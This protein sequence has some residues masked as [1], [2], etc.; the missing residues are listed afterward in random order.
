MSKQNFQVNDIRPQKIMA[1]YKKILLQDI[2]YLIKQKKDFIKINCP[3]C[4]G[5]RSTLKF[6]KYSLTYFE[7]K[8]CNTVYVNPRPTEMILNDFFKQS[9]GYKYWNDY[10]FPASEKVRR[11]KIFKPRV[12]KILRICKQ[13]SIPSET[14]VEV[15]AG[16]GTFL[17]E[18]S[19][20]K[21]FNSLIGIEPTPNL[22][23][24]CRD[25]NLNIIEK[26]IEEISPKTLKADVVVN[27]EVIEH[28]FSP[29]K[30]LQSCN[31]ILK[32]DGIL[33]ITCPNI[34]G[35]DI[36]TLGAISD[37]IDVEH[38]NYFNPESLTLLLKETGFVVL[39]KQTPGMLDTDLVRNKV[40][41]NE[42][43]LDNPLLKMILIDRWK[44]VGPYFQEFLQNNLLSSNMMI[45]AKKTKNTY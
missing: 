12:D 22:A 20:R 38:L 26:L 42:Y 18:L 9:K 6:R 41:S 5:S 24:T 15:G 33:I 2:K 37:T 25:K 1:N 28:I 23:K 21:V 4:N 40:L 32:K 45:I 13:Y 34:L 19:T 7:C 30:F 27:F 10:I 17:Q 31:K 35:F 44:E 43:N 29:K 14:L 8:D 16:F 39:E 36:Q 3:A 11:E